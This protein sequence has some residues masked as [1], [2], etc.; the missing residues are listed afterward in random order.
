[1]GI[2]LGLAND[3]PAICWG[4]FPVYGLLDEALIPRQPSVGLS[5]M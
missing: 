2:R 4:M 5:M 1:M 3:K